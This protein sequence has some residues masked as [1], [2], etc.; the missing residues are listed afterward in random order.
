MRKKKAILLAEAEQA[1][2]RRQASPQ[3]PS[4]F[5]RFVSSVSRSQQPAERSIQELN[6]EVRP[7][8]RHS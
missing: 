8:I 1:K 5:R 6:S 3:Q 2:R 7:L 4:L